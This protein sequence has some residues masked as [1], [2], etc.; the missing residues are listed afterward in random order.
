[1]ARALVGIIHQI[2]APALVHGVTSLVGHIARRGFV[3]SRRVLSG[4]IALKGLCVFARPGT[5]MMIG[6]NQGLR[7]ETMDEAV[8][9]VELPVGVRF[10]PHAVEPDATDFA[11]IRKQFGQLAV[12]EI[13]ILVPVAAFRAS[14]SVASAA[15]R[16]VVG[17]VPV[18]LR[19]VE[20]NLDP[21][22]VAF[23]YELAND[24]FPIGSAVNHVLI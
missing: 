16:I 7:L 13:E 10:V 20:K 9:I 21:L 18:E 1:F 2:E 14:R 6:N 17:M 8:S 3:K 11:I 12:H 5:L 22:L 24:I 4:Q 23:I 19:I 15:E